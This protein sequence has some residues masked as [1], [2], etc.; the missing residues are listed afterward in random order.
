MA[1]RI[2][3]GGKICDTQFDWNGKTVAKFII[4]GKECILK[5]KGT[6]GGGGGTTPGGLPPSM[7][8][9]VC[10]L[11]GNCYI[12]RWPDAE[13]EKE[14]F[15]ITTT[16]RNN[17]FKGATHLIG[18][19]MPQVTRIGMAGF[20]GCTE[21]ETA[22]FPELE[23]I[24]AGVFTDC[25]GLK[26][27]YGPKVKTIGNDAF[28]HDRLWNVFSLKLPLEWPELTTLG[29]YSLGYNNLP[30]GTH[31]KFPKLTTAVEMSVGGVTAVDTRQ[32]VPLLSP[33]NIWGDA[34]SYA[35]NKIKTFK[36]HWTDGAAISRVIYQSSFLEVVEFENEVDLTKIN[37]LSS[38][39]GSTPNPVPI[40]KMPNQTFIARANNGIIYVPTIEISG[41]TTIADD[42]LHNGDNWIKNVTMKSKFNTQAE[43]DR[44]FGVKKDGYGGWATINFTWVP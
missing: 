16:V 10:G 32:D 12:G 5:A 3:L 33:Q 25:N 15:R 9:A 30:D 4:G 28:V 13:E 18:V 11:H 8:G 7:D 43:K 35:S 40:L 34:G 31:V 2:I 24:D 14:F 17:E 6:T 1:N 36:T 27:F 26:N 20:Q 41:A 39:S 21:L 44:I 42:A 29:E 38:H 23:T 37:F 19:H 22:S